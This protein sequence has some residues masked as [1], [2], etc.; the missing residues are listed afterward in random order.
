MPYRICDLEVTAPLPAIALREDENGVGILVRRHSHPV[1]FWMERLA[2]GTEI[3]AGELAPRISARLGAKLLN[4]RLREALLAHAHACHPEHSEGPR[5]ARTASFPDLHEKT[6]H[7]PERSAERAV[8]GSRGAAVQQSSTD[9][10]MP[11]RSAQDDG[12][13]PPLTIAICTKD[14]PERLARC[15]SSMPRDVLEILVIDNAPS[16]QRTRELV[17]ANPRC[18]YVCEPKAGLDF[19]RN[20]AL[21]EAKGELLAFIDDDVVLDAGWLSGLMEAWRENSDAAAFTGLIL[22]LELQSEAQILFE[23]LGGFRGGPEHGFEKIRW[24][25]TLPGY[26][27]YPCDAGIFGAGAN[28]TFRRDAL[29]A[30]GGFDE[31]LDTGAPLPGGGDLDIFYR[32]VRAGHAIAYE[33]R[34]MVWHEH[35]R[36]LDALRRQYWSWGIGFMAFA[37]KSFRTD[38]SQ[39]KKWRRLVAWWFVKY[40]SKQLAKA[41]LGRAAPR[42]DMVLAEIVGAIDGLLGGYD[43]SARRS[44][45]IRCEMA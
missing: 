12:E 26:A 36:E 9:P 15:L 28:M 16:D 40:Q 24:G 2:P 23:E 39:R 18:R 3:S 30:L 11:L 32:L 19:A 13:F 31:A 34:C 42:A 25:Q 8:E 10:L 4:E 17:T 6:L 22:P 38:P 35:R 29:M 1:G 44:A 37:V 7:H 14:R 27:Q 33:P 20:R 5:D 41:L 45:R 43:R 21:H